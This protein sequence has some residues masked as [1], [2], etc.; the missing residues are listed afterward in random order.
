PRPLTQTGGLPYA[1][2][3]GNNYVTHGIAAMTQRLRGDRAAIGL[4]T[5]NGWYVTKHSVAVW[6]AQ[7]PRNEWR[8]TDPTLD[9]ATIDAEPHPEFIAD[10][11]GAATVET[12][13]VVFEREGA[14]GLGI[15]IGR[16]ARGRRFIANT[17]HDVSL[18]E[19]MTQR[20]FIGTKGHV[21]QS[22]DGK[23]VFTP[24]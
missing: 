2:G 8:R 13:T 15:V 16:G 3:P 12:Y 21:T 4:T 9:Q 19:S 11:E 5:G 7:P 6:S 23:N 17:P 22:S 24:G 10:P 20:E 1:G 18:L 14:P